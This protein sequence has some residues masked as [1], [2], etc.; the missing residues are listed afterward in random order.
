[1][2]ILQAVSKARR[3]KAPDVSPGNYYCPGENPA[4]HG[5]IT[6]QH[7]VKT[8]ST[9]PHDIYNL[10]KR[11]LL[12]VA[13]T[14]RQNAPVLT[15]MAKPKWSWGSKATGQRNKNKEEA[16]AK[17]FVKILSELIAARAPQQQDASPAKEAHRFAAAA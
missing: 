6:P 15:S 3:P 11:D 9:T 2:Q 8:C 16:A 17:A 14:A 4:R 7:A 13:A 10:Y 1:M 5:E 12:T